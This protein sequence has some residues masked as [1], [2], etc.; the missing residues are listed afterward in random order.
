MRRCVI[1]I[2]W[3][4]LVGAVINIAA[5]WG[6]EVWIDAAPCA[7]RDFACQR[8]REL[9]WRGYRWSQPGAMCV[10]EVLGESSIA[11]EVSAFPMSSNVMPHWLEARAIDAD[12]LAASDGRV[13]Y[14]LS[15]ARGWP[16]LSM[17]SRQQR[18]EWPRVPNKVE[19]R[20]NGGVDPSLPS[21]FFLNK[22]WSRCVPLRPIWTGFALNSAIYAAA[23][24]LSIAMVK[25]IIKRVRRARR[26][27]PDCGYP[28]GLTGVCSECGAALPRAVP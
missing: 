25:L 7:W 28:M 6:C 19:L 17:W 21:I 8:D 4:L 2:G 11:G 12:D 3:L 20:I 22:S 15:D 10:A 1:S 23:I 14:V 5:A 27:C 26:L 13:T 16:F 9:P 24:W 18:T